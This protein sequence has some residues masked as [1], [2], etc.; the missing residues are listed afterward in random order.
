MSTDLQ[1]PYQ[2]T[3]LSA[4]GGSN[5]RLTFVSTSGFRKG[6]RVLLKDDN[7]DAVELIVDEIVSGT[8]LT[9][10]LESLLSLYDCSAYTTGQN[11]ALTQNEQTDIYARTWN[12]F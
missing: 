1:V 5:G 10:R 11:A 4:N 7:T 9:V 3:A 12:W 8:V 2:K 6:A